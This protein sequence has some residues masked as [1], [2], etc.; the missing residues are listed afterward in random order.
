MMCSPARLAANQANSK[1]STGPRT[2]EG[3]AI[4]RGNA[5]KHGLTGQGI[6]LPTEDAAAVARRF[7]ELE[8]DLRPSNALS[9][10]LVQRMAMLAVRLDRCVEHESALMGEKVRHARRDHDDLRQAEVARLVDELAND[11]AAAVRH[12]LRTPEGVDRMTD[13]W[14][15]L[16]AD[17]TRSKYPR[18]TTAHR[19]RAIH[20]TGRKVQDI[21]VAP[22]LALSEALQGNFRLME[23][24]PPEG[25]D[26]AGRAAWALARLVEWIDD[27]LAALRDYRES[28]DEAAFEKD[29]VDAGRRALFDTSAE[30]TLARKYEAAAERG[31]FRSL[32]EFRKSQTQAAEAP[33]SPAPA[34]PAPELPAPLASSFPEDPAPPETEGPTP[35]RPAP[36]ADRPSLA[37]SRPDCQAGIGHS[38]DSPAMAGREW[39]S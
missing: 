32:H 8:T 12:L 4:S 21:P 38:V 33:R 26:P 6:A 36:A 7:D 23:E 1:R 37:P 25:L 9:R 3:K 5:L 31:F 29:R 17:L 15:D 20:L 16:R 18:W 11:P 39:G 30:A 35:D 2:P 14:L 28:L 19:D 22:I 34:P 27:E 24:Q 13:A 10:I